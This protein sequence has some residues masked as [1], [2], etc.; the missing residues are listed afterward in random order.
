[1]RAA[2]SKRA[3][4]LILFKLAV[5]VLLFGG[6]GGRALAGDGGTG[7]KTPNPAPSRGTTTNMK[8]A[9][10]DEALSTALARRGTASR[11]TCDGPDPLARRILNEYGSVF[12][13]SRARGARHT[14][15]RSLR[16]ATPRPT[17]DSERVRSG[18]LCLGRGDAAARLHLRGCRRG[19]DV[20]AHGTRRSAGDRRGV[21]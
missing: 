2:F 8:V 17:P 11:V 20:P 4:S 13:A 9:S 18:L 15:A 21:D 16:G 7:G 10:F 5:A 14:T 3:T 1:M 12:F 19:R 6:A